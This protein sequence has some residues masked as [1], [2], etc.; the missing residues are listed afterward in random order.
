MTVSIS[1]P[2]TEVFIYDGYGGIA[3][4]E[5]D[6]DQDAIF[7][8][9]NL[10]DGYGSIEEHFINKEYSWYPSLSDCVYDID[11]FTHLQLKGKRN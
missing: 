6:W 3:R 9:G 8:R 10:E 5:L 1:S 7:E 2:Y 4:L 11:P